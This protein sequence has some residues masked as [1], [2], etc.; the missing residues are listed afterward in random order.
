MLRNLYGMHAPARLLMERKIVAAVSSRDHDAISADGAAR[1][2]N[3][4]MPGMGR[5]NI[6]LDILIGRD[7]TLHP[8]DFFLGLS[9][10]LTC[11]DAADL[12][13]RIGAGLASEPS[14]GNGKE[15]AHV[16]RVD[17]VCTVLHRAH[18]MYMFAKL[19]SVR[20][21]DHTALGR[22]PSCRYRRPQILL[23]YSPGHQS[24]NHPSS[25]A[26]C[27]CLT[28]ISGCS[29]TPFSTFSKKGMYRREQ[30]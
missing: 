25:P 24:Q 8:A 14:L 6:H 5:S 9:A 18:C 16:K 17:S 10:I 26:L 21:R 12:A 27:P 7:E 22:S 20:A 19:V 11:I 2:Q 30:P 4:H 29:R 1:A 15:T 3:P 13:I 23:I 28:T